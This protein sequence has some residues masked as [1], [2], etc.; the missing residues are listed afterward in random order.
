MIET[1]VNTQGVLSVLGGLMRR[2]D[3]MQPALAEIGEDMTESMKRHFVDAKAPDS[4]AWA[5]NSDVTVA[6]YLGLFKDSYKK[7]GALSKRGAARQASK[8]P[9]TGETKALQT[10]INYQLVG[11][12][13][14][15]IGSPMVYAAM[16]NYGGTREAFPH[17]W[18]DIPARPFAGF[19]AADRAN[20]V[21]IVQSYILGA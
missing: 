20:I 6:I 12:D 8:K 13:T 10:T 9:G 3:Y 19:S 21:D 15:S 4:T 14:V 2:M 7:D 16:F 11:N 18:G 17:L 5:P 1:S